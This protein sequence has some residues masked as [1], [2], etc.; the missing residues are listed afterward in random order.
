MLFVNNLYSQTIYSE[1]FEN[2]VTLFSNSGGSFYTGS[3]GLGDS[4]SLS[5]YSQLNSYGFGKSNG[6]AILTSSDFN[7]N[8][9][10]NTQL[11]FRLAAFS[12]NSIGNGMEATDYVKVEVSPNG[13]T[14]YYNTIQINGI[15]NARWS[16]LGGLATANTIYDGDAS[17]I[18][19]APAGGG[20][21]TLDGYSTIVVTGLPSASNLRI[22][23]TLAND[24]ANE[25]WVIDNFLVTGT[26]TTCIA[27]TTTIT[28]TQSVCANTATSFTVGT[29]A[30]SP[31]YTWQS[32]ANGISGWGN[33]TDGIPSGV[34][35]SGVNTY[36][37]SVTGT[38]SV[39]YFYRV[40]V[41]EGGTCTAT[42]S[43][44]TLNIITSPSI[45]SQPNSVTTT[46]VSSGSFSIQAL[47]GSLTYQWQQ[48]SGSGYSNITNGGAFPT[49]AGATTSVLTI[50]NPP[51]SM[52][53][54]SYQCIVQ[55]N[56]GLIASNGTA[57]LNVTTALQCPHMTGVVV[58]ACDGTCTEGRNELVFF[59]S[60]DYSI[61]VN[62]ANIILKYGSTNPPTATYSDGFT[63]NLLH[64]ASLV[65]MAGCGTL[66]VDAS[67]AGVIPAHSVFVMMKHTACFNYD[68]SAFC[69]LGTIYVLYSNDPTWL[70]AGNFANSG[71]AGE[72]RYFRTDFSGVNAGCV[73]DYNYEPNKL[74]TNSGSSDGASIS[75]SS[76]GSATSYVN[77]GCSPSPIIL[78]IKLLDFY[79]TNYENKNKIFWK[80]TVEDNI[81]NYVIEKS[82]D[83]VN[84]EAIGIIIPS[85]NTGNKTYSIIDDEPFDEITYYRLSTT[86]QDD[87][88]MKHKVI[89]IDKNNKDWSFVYYQTENGLCID[90]KNCVP[91]NSIINLVDITGKLFATQ[92]VNSTQN[93]IN[94]IDFSQGVYF[95]QIT[96]PYKTQNFKVFMH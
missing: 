1:D 53:G 77:S 40:L 3:T 11:S 13:G 81:K 44:S 59:N 85:D 27:P 33:L 39:S 75:F 57:T 17:P 60:G 82:S 37:L 8:N 15:S 41:S 73:S 64:T 66:I 30:S 80:V 51:L 56:C 84:Y 31:S 18:V 35:Y 68:F 54:Y 65:S 67:L 52:N 90:F 21:R 49:F 45:T 71:T 96:S 9:C 72:L 25:R 24:D 10:S 23:I 6:T 93:I 50:S 62:P 14:N 83:A 55:N 4:P 19:F 48:N 12:I 26:C 87:D 95:I 34:T 89:S 36:S 38:N 76:S 74:T 5:P 88:I 47:G 94:T 92:N 16:Y 7:T 86:E 32:S 69:G 42:S 28:Q 70:D 43:T 46:S 58:N 91:K 2:S 79:A 61:P 22:R 78:P 20:T 29:N 63:T